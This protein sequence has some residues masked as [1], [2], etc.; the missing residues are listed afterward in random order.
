MLIVYTFGVCETTASGTL[1]AKL[2]YEVKCIS[3]Y[4]LLPCDNLEVLLLIYGLCKETEQTL[5]CELFSFC[6]H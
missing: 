4:G 6:F 5:I 2:R 1:K 3:S